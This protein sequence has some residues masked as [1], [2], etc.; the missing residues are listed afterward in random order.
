[1]THLLFDQGN[2]RTKCVAVCDGRLLDPADVDAP[3]DAAIWCSVADTMPRDQR[4]AWLLERAR[5]AWILDCDTPM[6]MKLRYGVPRTLGA[7]RIAAAVGALAACPGTDV[8][9]VDA[10]TCVT[11]DW[12]SASGVF[13]GGN[14]GPGVEMQLEA[15]HRHTARLPQVTLAPASGDTFGHDTSTAL[16]LGVAL[17]IAGQAV[18]CLESLPRPRVC[19]LTGGDARELSAYLTIPHTVAPGLLMDGLETILQHLENET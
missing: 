9:V 11:Y 8:L 13:M 2:T 6:P 16:S 18:M 5:R 14:I 12:V 19:L 3:A 10:G 4:M 17:G 1:M 7:D 15:M